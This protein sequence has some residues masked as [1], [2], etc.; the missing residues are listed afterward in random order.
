M[1]LVCIDMP[2]ARHLLHLRSGEE[3]VE[4]ADIWLAEQAMQHALAPTYCL[5][6]VGLVRLLAAQKFFSIHVHWYW[7]L[8]MRS[9]NDLKEAP[10]SRETLSSAASVLKSVWMLVPVSMWATWS[11]RRTS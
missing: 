10:A 7:S 9:R 8:G 2:D 1:P 5:V 4:Q 3:F 6:D 11:A